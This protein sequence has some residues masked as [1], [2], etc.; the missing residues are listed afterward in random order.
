MKSFRILALII[1][2]MRNACIW[3]IVTKSRCPPYYILQGWRHISAILNVIVRQSNV[4]SRPNPALTV[5]VF[6]SLDYTSL[7]C[8]ERISSGYQE[9]ILEQ[10]EKSKMAAKIA[11]KKLNHLILLIKSRVISLFPL[12][13]IREIHFWGYFCNLRSITRSNIIFKVI[14]S[15]IRQY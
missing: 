2:R 4:I 9:D 5:K 11:K 6:F 15:T 3:G 1:T 7:G 14:Y 8:L 10:F 12:N 13:V